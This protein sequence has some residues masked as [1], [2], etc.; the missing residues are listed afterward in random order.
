MDWEPNAT[1]EVFS[2]K[3]KKQKVKV[4][5]VVKSLWNSV[6][7]VVTAAKKP[8]TT[9]AQRKQFATSPEEARVH[10]R[11]LNPKGARWPTRQ[12][13]S[14]L[15]LPGSGSMGSSTATR[16]N[17]GFGAFYCPNYSDNSSS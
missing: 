17:G 5:D 15:R 13:D 11:A 2:S 3:S 4:G 8:T 1:V 7:I 14:Q 9:P 16:G 12:A 10:W 6:H